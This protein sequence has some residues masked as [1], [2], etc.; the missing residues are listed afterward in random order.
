MVARIQLT[1]QNGI[2]LPSRLRAE[3]VWIIQGEL[4][5]ETKTIE[6]RS[7]ES[8][9]YEF[10]IRGGPKL[11]PGS[12]VDVVVRLVDEKGTTL[13]LALRHQDIKAVS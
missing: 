7:D 9:S 4:V 2:P 1:S 6:A 12:Y 10:V 8:G 11:E 5:W 13:N 3:I